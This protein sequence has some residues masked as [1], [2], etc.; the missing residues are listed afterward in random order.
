MN[1]NTALIENEGRQA[2]LN[3][4]SSLAGFGK[5][6]YHSQVLLVHSVFWHDVSTEPEKVRG[7]GFRHHLEAIGMSFVNRN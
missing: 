2:T 5:S 4:D 6:S 1:L 3:C 7:F